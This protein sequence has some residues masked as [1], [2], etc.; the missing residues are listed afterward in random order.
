MS[1]IATILIAAAGSSVLTAVVTGIASFSVNRASAAKLRTERDNFIAEAAK[2][3]QGIADEAATRALTQVQAQ[4]DA[5]ERRLE[6]AEKRQQLAEQRQYVA[7]ERLQT[8][9]AHD[10]QTRSALRTVVRAVDADDPTAMAA[11]IAAA[12]ELV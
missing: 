2:K 10:R 6:I 1:T 4:C 11:A 9:E 12:R 8:V 5:C 3:W 7:E